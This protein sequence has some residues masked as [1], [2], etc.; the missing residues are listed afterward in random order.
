MTPHYDKEVFMLKSVF[1][2]FPVQIASTMW[3]SLNETDFTLEEDVNWIIATHKKTKENIEI[4]LSNVKQIKR[5]RFTGI[6][7]TK[8]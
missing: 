5:W 7:Q 8:T 1:V 6:G 3:N 4:P 2:I